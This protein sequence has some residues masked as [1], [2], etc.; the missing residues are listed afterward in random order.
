MAGFFRE[1]RMRP[2]LL[3]ALAVFLACAG[4]PAFAAGT[5]ESTSNTVAENPDWTAAKAAI[6]QK[7]YE[8]A[9]PLLLRAVDR[10]PGNADAWNYLGYINSR[11]DK[12]A[13]A[14]SYYGKALALAPK[15]RGAN[16][17]LGELYL[18]MGDLAKAEE[19]LAVLDDACFFGCAEYDLLKKAVNEYKRTGKYVPQKG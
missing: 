14:L 2:L 16:E 5:T 1:T 7:D 11:A 17:Y 15:H 10:D 3:A 12:P 6:A 13:A 19:R 18:K 9:E 8:R 4:T